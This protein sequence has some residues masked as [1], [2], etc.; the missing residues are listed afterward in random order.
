MDRGVN[1]KKQK[2]KKG[3]NRA[4]KLVKVAQESGKG[5]LKLFPLHILLFT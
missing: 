5:E 2:N 3:T 1:S 4:T